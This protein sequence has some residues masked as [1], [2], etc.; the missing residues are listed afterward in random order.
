MVGHFQFLSHISLHKWRWRKIEQEKEASKRIYA[1]KLI[2]I[3]LN[4]EYLRETCSSNFF[5]SPN[6]QVCKIV[7]I[8]FPF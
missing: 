5:L 1:G 4:L 2:K 6:I 3:N 7:T 8:S